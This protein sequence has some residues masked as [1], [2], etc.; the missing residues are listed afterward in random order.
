MDTDPRNSKYRIRLDPEHWPRPTLRMSE[1]QRSTIKTKNFFKFSLCGT[2]ST[3]IR[4]KAGYGTEHRD[5]S[6]SN[7]GQFEEFARRLD[8]I[9]AQVPQVR[10]HLHNTHTSVRYSNSTNCYYLSSSS[11]NG[12]LKLTKY[13]SIAE[14][15]TYQCTRT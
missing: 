10:L 3:L 9:A 14:P 5:H 11:G 2:H 13:Q 12:R 7:L 15:K 4:I 8:E 6:V 1:P